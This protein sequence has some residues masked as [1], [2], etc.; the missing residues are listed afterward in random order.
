MSHAGALKMI[1]GEF[2]MNIHIVKTATRKRIIGIVAFLRRSQIKGSQKCD[3]AIHNLP[4]SNV[5]VV[6]YLFAAKSQ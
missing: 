4:I 3:M 1:R 2:Q 5:A 6:Q